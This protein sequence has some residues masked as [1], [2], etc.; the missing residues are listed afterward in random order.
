MSV[1]TETVPTVMVTVH[2]QFAINHYSL[3]TWDYSIALDGGLKYGKFSDR[4]E[5]YGPYKRLLQI[6]M[7]NVLQGRPYRKCEDNTSQLMWQY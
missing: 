1:N 7:K 6:L 4:G 2:L 5:E 3:C